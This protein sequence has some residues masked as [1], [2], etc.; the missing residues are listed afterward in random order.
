M[1]TIVSTEVMAQSHQLDLL[2]AV[3]SGLSHN[4]L[5]EEQR[6]QIDIAVGA[7]QIETGTFDPL[8]QGSATQ[9]L[10]NAAPLIPG[11]GNA[12]VVGTENEMVNLTD[13]SFSGSKLYR[14]GISISPSYQL[15][16]TT[17][18][19]LY[20]SGFNS[21]VA[22]VT[23][24]IPLLRGRGAKVLAA[25]ER[26][27]E[28]E[29]V[30]SQFD[31][32]FLIANLASTIAQNYWG[33]V[34]AYR[35]LDVATSAEGRGRTYVENT[36]ALIDA[37]HVPRADLNEVQS[38]LAQRTE[39]RISAQNAVIVARQTLSQS[40]GLSA[41]QI[42]E[43]LGDPGDDF[44]AVP[45]NEGPSDSQTSLR[46]DLNEA[47][48]QRADYLAALTRKEKVVILL[49]AAENGLLPALNVIVGGGYEGLH[50]G[51]EP[52]NLFS[53]FY[54]GVR[55]PNASGGLSY[56][57]PVGNHA[58]RGALEQAQ[59]SVRQADASARDVARSIS[60]NLTVAVAGVRSA[61]LRVQA[62][63]RAVSLTEA[64]L[65]GARDKYRGGFGSVVEILQVEDRLNSVLG[66]EVQ[67]RLDYSLA[68]V[69]YRFAI[70]TLVPTNQQVPVIRK[71]A[72]M[73]PIND[74][75]Q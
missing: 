58:A 9:S 29:V 54:S 1:S 16:R 10:T 4:P 36:Q 56:S 68:L 57:F 38:N 35:N 24:T 6:A 59:A 19:F 53:S 8:L 67:A 55:G 40:L 18:S 75:Q 51:T 7:R 14:S 64:A 47:L 41:E 66:D 74:Q 60:Q 70:G 31:L 27:A 25:R 28:K 34:A 15:V 20:P 42:L 12:D 5:L 49:P 43:P 69:Q 2:E 32:D 63:Q 26:S 61:I 62:A 30:A 13:L 50:G 46:H 21:S 11:T 45:T 72:F 73:D 3:R 65:A 17:D 23:V 39:A 52:G 22:G 71:E 37:D 48:T 33:L 44:P